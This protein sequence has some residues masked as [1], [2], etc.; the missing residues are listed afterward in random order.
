MLAIY[1][2][3]ADRTADVQQKTLRIEK[4]LQRRTSN[5]SFRVIDGTKPSE[6]EELNIY[7][8]AEVE[9][10]AGADIVLKESYEL[11]TNAFYTGQKLWL[12]VEQ[13]DAEQAIV[14]SYDEST[15]TVTLTA[16]PATALS[17]GDIIGEKLF[18]GRVSRV[19][20]SNIEQLENIQYDVTGVD[21]T[22][23]Y[24]KKAINDA[25]AD[26]DVQYIVNDFLNTTVNYNRTLDNLVYD[27][28]AAIQ[29]EW[30]DEA[31][32]A[33][34]PT[35]DTTDYREG[36]ASGVFNWSTLGGTAT[37]RAAVTT[38]DI[39]DLT[40]VAIGTPTQGKLM[41]WAKPTNFA[42]TTSFK[43]RIG[44]SNAD[45]VEVDFGVPQNNDWNY[46]SEELKN[47]TPAGNPDWENVDY[48][49]I[50]VTQTL[51]ASIKLNGLRVNDRTA[52]TM[53]NVEPSTEIDDIR[54]PQIKPIKFTD[55]LAKAVGKVW[56]IDEEQDVHI[57]DASAIPA[58]FEVTET[59][60]NFY[61]LAVDIDTSKLGNRIIVEGGEKTSTSTYSQV[62][63]GDNARREFNLRTKFNNLEI[64]LDN[65]SV[66]DTAEA[67]TTTTTINATAHGLS[68]GDYITNRSRN[69][70]VRKVLTVPDPNSFTVET[71]TG[72]TSGDTFSLFAT[73]KTVGPE[74]L[75]DETT[76]DYVSNSN[77]QSVRATDSEATLATGEFLLFTYNERIQLSLQVP[78]S[79]SINALKAAGLGDGI[80]DL[81]VI[82]DR[83]ITS[84]TEAL[85]VA[86][87]AL[88]QFSNPI[89]KATFTTDQKGLSAGQL[90]RIQDSISRS[91]DENYVIQ[92]IVIQQRD[93][94]YK[95]YMMYTVTAGTT[96]FGWEEFMQKLLGTKTGI[97]INTDATI[98][99]FANS[100]EQV[101]V[102]D[103]NQVATGGGLNPA[104]NTE[105][106]EVSETNTVTEFTPPW[107]WEPNGVGQ[108]LNTRWNL[109]EWS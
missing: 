7:L 59:S 80:Y 69:N 107:K 23:F 89:V 27:D 86:N 36:A 66:T 29:A 84:T 99:H 91:L 20:D 85:V 92:K 65:N 16:A 105:I 83:N 98:E 37:W 34:N 103:T 68:E 5:C 2:N 58:P 88:E 67:G 19:R 28:N 108:P 30:I 42:R 61:N 79:A 97:E 106:V 10:Q 8:T 11:N 73:S 70:A 77:A 26:E 41:I 35:V 100:L 101:D 72:Q 87:A 33:D 9:S 3:S 64:K 31:N 46:L 51:D 53:F 13:S 38:S 1:I 57:A 22:K 50:R 32:D 93:G 14:D 4:Q 76:V 45:Y 104:Q 63:E 81:D 15:K 6:N 94:R 60:D 78:N 109:S 40:G 55:T 39:S 102:V 44:S 18:G 54:S 56:W 48:V 43:V 49:Q 74:G 90:L 95:D 17:D 47:G 75:T 21:H 52:F 62:W 71:I 82:V 24:D 25:W 96:L 12:Q